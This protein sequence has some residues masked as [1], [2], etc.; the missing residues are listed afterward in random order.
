MSIIDINDIKI[1]TK[2][3]YNSYNTIEYYEV[4]EI[5]DIHNIV[6]Y[7]QTGSSIIF[8]L[9][10]NCILYEYTKNVKIIDEEEYYDFIKYINS[11]KFDRSKSL[12]CIECDSSVISFYDNVNAN[13]LFYCSNHNCKNHNEFMLD[14]IVAIPEWCYINFSNMF[15]AFIDTQDFCTICYYPK[16]VTIDSICYCANPNCI[17][18][19]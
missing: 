9:D 4:K 8:C 6:C 10:K 17:N 13:N 16:V 2:I 19:I 18:H 7:T 11:V 14:N 15:S 1:G 5:T 12:Y 3:K